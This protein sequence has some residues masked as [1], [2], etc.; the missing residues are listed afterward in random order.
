MTLPPRWMKLVRDFEELGG[1][2]ALVVLAMIFG[3][4]CVIAI[5]GGFATLTRDIA[6]AYVDTT[7][8]SGI[9]DVGAVDDAMVAR[10]RAM[11]GVAEAEA[12]TILHTRTRLPDGSFGRGILFVS[13]DP[14]RQRIGIQRIE[15]T[16]PVAGPAVR[17]ER[18]SVAV[19][20]TSLGGIVSFDLPGAGFVDLAVA[21][22]VFDPALAA[23]EQEQATYAYMDAATW[24]ALG[25]GPLEMIEVRV[26]GAVADQAHVDATLTRLA[27]TLRAEG[28]NVHLVQIPRA[29]T[30]PHQSQMTA[31]L[32][33]FLVF[34][35]A[36]FLLSAFL[37]SVTIDGLMVQQVRQIGVMKTIGA[38]ARQIRALYLVGVAI[39]GAAALAV[40]LPLGQQAGAL[41]SRAV[42]E[43][44]N[45]DL[46]TTAP[47]LPLLG[48][49]V[50]TGL[51]VPV[52]FALRPL[53]RAT[54][55][56]VIAAV[57]DQGIDA[58]SAVPRV[59][60]GV[61]GFGVRRL[62]LAGVGRNAARS[63]LI[64]GLLAS[65]GAVTL[66]ARNVA[67]S[68]GASV[69]IAA[70][71]RRHDVDIRLTAPLARAQARAIADAVG[72]EVLDLP[73]ALEAAPARADGLAVVR[74]YPDGGHGSL[75]LMALEDTAS[76]A[77]LAPL[78]GNLS[79]GFAGGIVLNQSALEMLGNPAIGDSISLSLD[80]AAMT[81]PLTAVLRQY[82]NPATAYVAAADLAAQTGLS[83][84]N[85]LRLVVP[86]DR[87]LAAE[88]EARAAS[89]GSGVASAFTEN[90]M[91]A[92]VSGHI[93]ILIVMLTALGAMIS[94][95]GFV[96]LTA[97][98][99][100]AVVERRREFGVLRAIGARRRQILGTLMWE[101]AAFWLAALALA[102]VLSL[103]LS[104]WVG[105]QIGRM[106]FGMALPFA[107]DWAA[108]ALW[109]AVSLVG[110]LIASLPPG[111]AAARASVTSSLSRQ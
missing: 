37:V 108:T 29:E 31:V 92:A 87:N 90:Q 14:D 41:L 82:M 71:E 103:P 91:G 75:T 102:V 46:A 100:I 59:L 45:F 50:A 43:L 88:V 12:L 34:G 35:I 53:T 94:V 79:G 73:Y 96:G 52:I 83:G 68:Y 54:S 97:A 104:W 39:L 51:I 17:L 74:T 42:S 61:A 98:Q 77:H 6:R 57:N 40:A 23:A 66:T 3:L 58:P 28:V 26:A 101:G 2:L 25:G 49:W 81:L 48:F 62:A 10:V 18:R 21:G 44:L 109:A 95:V 99:G 60:A 4:V 33:M 56:P 64:I 8:A 15:V 32:A 111:M 27:G 30:H 9:L 36:A 65:A 19:A 24:T 89:L 72:A 85:A 16:V 22:A 69:E 67:A 20:R 5:T 106:T 55:M 70:E 76:L 80:G 84:A 107:L 38:R 11:P 86:G 63:V 1:R 78:A 7:P 13:P 93:Y 105:G 110:A 47:S